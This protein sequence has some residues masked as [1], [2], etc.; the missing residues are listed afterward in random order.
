[1]LK[2]YHLAA[3]TTLSLPFFSSSTFSS[4]IFFSSS[5]TTLL[6]SLPP[7]CSP[8][9]PP[10]PPLSSLPP[11]QPFPPPL[12]PLYTP[13]LYL[14]FFL[15]LRSTIS[16]CDFSTC[17]NKWIETTNSH[18]THEKIAFT[19]L[20]RGRFCQYKVVLKQTRDI[21]TQSNLCV[22]VTNRP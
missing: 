8:S 3:A 21:I 15:P 19:T 7:L 12:P 4:F 9:P 10:P 5:V 2:S 1:M 16:S 18:K 14:F 17:W 6:S 13:L 11:P 20:L 22:E